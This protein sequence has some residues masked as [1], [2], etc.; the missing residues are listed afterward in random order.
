ME[1]L[2]AEMP[3]DAHTTPFTIQAGM[4]GQQYIEI[5]RLHTLDNDNSGSCDAGACSPVS[6]TTSDRKNPH[7]DK[8]QSDKTH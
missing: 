7:A 8:W 2:T 1:S 6:G 4:A 5:S 3:C